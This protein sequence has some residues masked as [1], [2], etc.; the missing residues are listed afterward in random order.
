LQWNINFSWKI[1]GFYLRKPEEGMYK[2]GVVGSLLLLAC[3]RS[4]S[5]G[6]VPGGDLMLDVGIKERG[7]KMDQSLMFN[8][9]NFEG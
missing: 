8:A 4:S 6:D 3:T 2:L 5:G 1:F 7:R 9:R